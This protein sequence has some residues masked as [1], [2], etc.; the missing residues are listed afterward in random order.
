MIAWKLIWNLATPN[1]AYFI[2][3]QP[4][5]ER[6]DRRALLPNWLDK[7]HNGWTS[8]E[9]KAESEEK[10][11]IRGNGIVRPIWRVRISSFP[12]T[13]ANV[14][15]NRKLHYGFDASQTSGRFRSISCSQLGPKVMMVHTQ[16]CIEWGGGEHVVYEA[17]YY[18]YA[19]ACKSGLAFYLTRVSPGMGNII[20]REY[21]DLIFTSRIIPG[22]TGKH[23]TL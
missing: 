12:F 16:K 7:E 10:D 13:A 5:W 9:E 17:V 2:H 1:R 14:A 18:R 6:S 22:I 23:F 3:E 8:G 20:S 11:E 21:I 19:C 4:T 15:L